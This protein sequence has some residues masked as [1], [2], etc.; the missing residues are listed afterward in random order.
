M[1]RVFQILAVV[2]LV[3]FAV[4]AAPPVNQTRALTITATND[5]PSYIGVAPAGGTSDL[6][7]L[8]QGSRKRFSV[9]SNGIPSPFTFGAA[10]MSSDGSVTQSFGVT[11]S[12]TPTVLS[13]QL[14]IGTTPTNILTVTVSNFVLRTSLAGQTNYWMAIGER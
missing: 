6:L 5:A 4:M 2:G 8:F 12:N 1:N 13:R 9:G 10:I 14:G 7:Q 3:V 11:Y